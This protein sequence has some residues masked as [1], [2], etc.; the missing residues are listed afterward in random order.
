MQ[1]LGGRELNDI[2]GWTDPQTGNEIALVGLLN[3][4]SFVD[5][6][7]PYAPR[8][9]G[10]LPTETRSSIWRDVKVFKNHAYIVADNA[11]YHGIQI[12]DLTQ[13]QKYIFFY[14]FPKNCLL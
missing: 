6:S 11:S 3:G 7:D 8:V 13:L 5:V 2:W 9:L 10:I 4:V 14:N 12:F 1:D